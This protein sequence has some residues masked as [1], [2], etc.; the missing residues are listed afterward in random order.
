MK[1]SDYLYLFLVSLG[2]AARWSGGLPR[3]I[4]SSATLD[5]LSAPPAAYTDCTPP[6]LLLVRNSR[7]PPSLLPAA[8]LLWWPNWRLWLHALAWK[9]PPS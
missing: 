8:G 6:P 9:V 7:Q 5:L 2:L 4:A 1:L 3:R